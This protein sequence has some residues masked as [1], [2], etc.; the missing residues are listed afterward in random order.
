M[1]THQNKITLSLK[2]TFLIFAMVLNCMGIIILQLSDENVSYHK[3]G[4]LESFKDFPI[5]FISL[6]AVN[7]ISRIGTK[8][9]L[10]I[11][12]SIVAFCS[13]LLPFAEVFWFYKL[14]F[15]IIGTCFAL[16]KI[17]VFSIIK[18]NILEEKTLAKTMNSVEASYMIGS[19]GVNAGFGL[20]IASRFGEYWKFGFFGISLICIYTLY[21]FLTTEIHETESKNNKLLPDLKGLRKPLFFAF[22][23]LAFFIVFTEQTFNSWLPS[24]YKK[25]LGVNSFLALQASA[26]LPFFSFLGRIVTSKI[27]KRFE[28]SKYFYFCIYMILI[29]LSTIILIQLFGEE[30]SQILLFIFPIIGFFLGP[31]YPIINSKMISVTE[32]EKINVLTSIIVIFSSLGS[33]ASSVLLSILFQ[34]SLFS[35]YAL[36]VFVAVLI[37]LLLGFS[38][39]RLIN[40]KLSK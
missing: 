30:K 32:K 34:K 33:S 28:L 38:F 19:F 11:A 39:F 6:F 21:L 12:L 16:G 9:S 25:H 2:L 31:I 7:F 36:Y 8:T 20:L 13:F 26:M 15:A 14:W 10:I 5:A 17:C 22:F 3:L 24:F 27:I 37:L 1:L 18:N 23:G 29:I 4:F 35:F 40:Q